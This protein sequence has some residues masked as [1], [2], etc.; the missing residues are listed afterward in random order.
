[1]H[2]PEADIVKLCDFGTATQLCMYY[3]CMYVCIYIYIYTCV[4]IYIYIYSIL[5][6]A[7]LSDITL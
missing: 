5:Y 7:I 6:Y 1:M 4:C 2:I 3:M